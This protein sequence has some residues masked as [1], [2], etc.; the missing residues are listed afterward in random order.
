MEIAEEIEHP[1]QFCNI[2]KITNLELKSKHYRGLCLDHDHK[3]NM[4][5]G[6]LCGPCNS[7][8]AFYEKEFLNDRV[9]YLISEYLKRS[10]HA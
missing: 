1:D 8:V 4:P 10:N 5:R 3:S 7:L 6:F 9:F 2:C